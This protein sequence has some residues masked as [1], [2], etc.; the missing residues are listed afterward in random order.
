MSDNFAIRKKIES[1]NV[2]NFRF[3]DIQYGLQ[4]IF[5][6]EIKIHGFDFLI[7][8]GCMIVGLYDKKI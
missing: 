1:I 4:D 2:N 7:P 6:S 5:S 8:G 3:Y